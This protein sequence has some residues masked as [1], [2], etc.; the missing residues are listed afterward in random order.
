MRKIKSYIAISLNGKIAK[1]D[2]SVGWLDEIPNPE[3]DDYGY[4]AFYESI[5]ATIQGYTTYKQI[6]DWGIDFPYSGKENYVLTKKQDLQD[7]SDVKFISENHTSF[8]KSLK[9][10]KGKDIWLIGGGIINTML[11][12]S[13]LIDE[14]YVFVMP[15]VLSGGIDLFGAIPNETQLV[16]SSSKNYNSGVVELRYLINKS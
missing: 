1:E 13:N 14:I 9:E 2:G 7:N 8:I 5:D 12:N 11:L 15:I 10:K 6:L 3:N 4:S 16:L